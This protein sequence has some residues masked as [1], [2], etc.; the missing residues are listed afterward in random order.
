ME[1]KSISCF[2]VSTMKNKFLKEL[3]IL[4]TLIFTISCLENNKTNED[5]QNIKNT[6]KITSKAFQ[7]GE[8]IPLKY[9]CDG[10]NISPPLEIENIPSQTKS[11]TLI[12]DDPDAPFQ[13]W[14]HWILFNLKA[15]I[16]E[17][18]EKILSDKIL[19]NGAIQ[20]LTSFNNNAYGGPCPPN[21]THRYYFKV[22]A[23]DKVLEL[24]SNAKKD[25]VLKEME[26][27]IL[28]KGELIGKYQRQKK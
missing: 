8:L 1:S 28:A 21:G 15:D 6:I 16:K 19:A 10:E 24:A 13:T 27:H 2:G 26:G 12:T 17:L 3:L 18:S 4:S 20:G 23:L 7:N 11:I 22:Y 25:D 14:V 9:T 5:I